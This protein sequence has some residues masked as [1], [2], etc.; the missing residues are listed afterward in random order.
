MSDKVWALVEILGHVRRVGRV[1]E[2]TRYGTEGIL[3]EVP[4]ADGSFEPENFYAG[5]ALFA[6]HR[7][8]ETE[9]R[10]A[11]GFGTAAALPGHRLDDDTDPDDDSDGDPADDS[12]PDDD[13][14]DPD[15][16]DSDSDDGDSD[17]DDDPT[18][19]TATQGLS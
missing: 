11:A 13:D 7:M 2:V 4:R 14:S 1:S 16:S 3:V 8:T 6:V 19:A 10:R 9:A 5:R 17:P 18:D 12:D 15:D